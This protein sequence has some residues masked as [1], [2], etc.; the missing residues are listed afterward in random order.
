[1][2]EAASALG[3]AWRGKLD[4][5][6]LTSAC[7]GH[8][9]PSTPKVGVDRRFNHDTEL[10][11][12]SPSEWRPSRHLAAEQAAVDQR[13]ETFRRTLHQSAWTLSVAAKSSGKRQGCGTRGRRLQ[14]TTLWG[15][16]GRRYAT[17]PASLLETERSPRPIDRQM[18]RI[19]SCGPT[20]SRERRARCR[21]RAG[22]GD[23]G[24]WSPDYC[25][26]PR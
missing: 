10:T 23:R 22:G 11:P 3:T 7:V 1:M 13:G 24:H 19:A 4:W 5:A 2:S 8:G 6:T 15:H 18:T 16:N 9:V 17:I 25:L 12:V 26:N 14:A 21:M 20:G